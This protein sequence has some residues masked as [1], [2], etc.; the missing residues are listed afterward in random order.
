MQRQPPH[1]NTAGLLSPLCCLFALD[2]AVRRT[3]ADASVSHPPKDSLCAIA[4]TLTPRALERD[5]SGA[6]ARLWEAG[7][8]D[9]AARRCNERAM[10]AARKSRVGSGIGGTAGS[11]GSHSGRAGSG[12]I[13]VG[14]EAWEA[15]VHTCIKCS[16]V[17]RE[18]TQIQ[19]QM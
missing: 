10:A 12:G 2:G 6:A 14:K 9:G 5:G 16:C 8:S 19:I 15:Q 4:R 13:A 11:Q 1:K 3:R 17:Q 18:G 7:R